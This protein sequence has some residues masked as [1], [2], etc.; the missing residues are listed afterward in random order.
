MEEAK[1]TKP[2]DNIR[3]E[4]KSVLRESERKNQRTQLR[5]VHWIINEKDT[6]PKLEKRTFFL[7]DG[8]PKTGK[9]VGLNG[10]DMRFIVSNWEEISHFFG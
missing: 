3:E 1:T 5:V 9:C 6:G 4:V 10:D 7:K 2:R 8:A